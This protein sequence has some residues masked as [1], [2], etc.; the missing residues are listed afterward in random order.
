MT[1]IHTVGLWGEFSGKHWRL[2]IFLQLFKNRHSV[3]M[4]HWKVVLF[5]FCLSFSLR[6][7]LIFSSSQLPSDIQWKLLIFSSSFKLNWNSLNLQD[8]DKESEIYYSYIDVRW[9]VIFLQKYAHYDCLMKIRNNY[10]YA[11]CDIILLNLLT[12]S[13]RHC[14]VEYIVIYIM[15]TI[16]ERKFQHRTVRVVQIL[17][18]YIFLIFYNIIVFE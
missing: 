16:D 11:S 12:K 8:N 9:W 14:S 4:W 6:L 2:S 7:M 3:A 13:M 1:L 5:L 15:K 17:Q 10:T 18:I